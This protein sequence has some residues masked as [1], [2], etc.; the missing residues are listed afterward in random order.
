MKMKRLI[1]ALLPLRMNC[2]RAETAFIEEFE[3]PEATGPRA[4]DTKTKVREFYN[5]FKNA[6]KINGNTECLAKL[7]LVDEVR[8]VP[9]I[10]GGLEFE[11]YYQ[12]YG[13]GIRSIRILDKDWSS[14]THLK[15]AVWHE[16]GHAIGKSHGNHNIL[17][18]SESLSPEEKESIYGALMEITK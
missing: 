5:E 15:H 4:A 12:D 14:T 11:G 16:M 7:A 9:H 10:N 1:L 2:G 18:K 13:H 8:V 17:M 6:C 3:G